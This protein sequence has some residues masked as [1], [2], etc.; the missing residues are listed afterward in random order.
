MAIIAHF[1]LKSGICGGKDLLAEKLI[2]S[3]FPLFKIWFK[4]ES[5]QNYQIVFVSILDTICNYNDI[6]Q[7]LSA[8]QNI[9][10]HRLFIFTFPSIHQN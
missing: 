10:S 8:V 7:I 3:F 9:Q 4:L 1:A 2:L 5:N 6:V